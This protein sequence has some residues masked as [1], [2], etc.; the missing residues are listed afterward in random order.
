MLETIWKYQA[1]QKVDIVAFRDSRCYAVVRS[2]HLVCLD[3][4]SGKELWSVK[5]E[6]PWGWI[7]VTRNYVFYLNQH[8]K[9]VAIATES[10]EE[11]W[12]LHLSDYGTGKKSPYFGWL[13]AIDGRVIVGGW[14]GCNDVFCLH[15]DDGT[16]LWSYPAKGKDLFGT[17]PYP[18]TG[19]IMIAS[20]S[21]S[22]WQTLPKGSKRIY[23]TTYIEP[24]TG[25]IFSSTTLD[26]KTGIIKGF[27]GQDGILLFIDL[28]SG[29]ETFRTSLPGKWSSWYTDR[30]ARHDDGRDISPIILKEDVNSFYRISGIP[31]SVEHHPVQAKIW[32]IN[33][34]QTNDV[35]PFLSEEGSLNIYSV[36]SHTSRELIRITHNRRYM[37]PFYVLPDGSFAVGTSIGLVYLISPEGELSAKRKIGKAVTT[38]LTVSN[39][40]LCCGTGSGEILGLSATE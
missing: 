40:I 8:E 29:A 22:Q 1:H 18:E 28:Q 3:L 7:A 11:I 35:V 19:S 37:L 21:R 15:A 10:G 34:L 30:I 17:Y 23:G 27:T 2:T 38:Q 39:G 12:S 4:V 16:L 24:Q 33:L 25:A 32:S 31:P 26:P 36:T 14:R 13:H 6:N 5:I 20:R 9:L